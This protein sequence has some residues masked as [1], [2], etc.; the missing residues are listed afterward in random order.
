MA[1]G[2]K[3]RAGLCLIVAVVLIWVA[4]AEVTQVPCIFFLYLFV[5]LLDLC[6]GCMLTFAGLILV[7][8]VGLPILHLGFLIVITGSPVIELNVTSYASRLPFG[9]C[10]LSGIMLNPIQGCSC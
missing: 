6:L 10:H 1:S 5:G 2:L 3:Y 7:V 8:C 4:S 9:E